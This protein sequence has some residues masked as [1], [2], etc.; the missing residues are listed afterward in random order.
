MLPKAATKCRTTRATATC[1]A[2]P[3]LRAKRRTADPSGCGS[4]AAPPSH[5]PCPWSQPW[6]APGSASAPG[7]TRRQAAVS[8][9]SSGCSS[10]VGA[11]LWRGARPAQPG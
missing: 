4:R 11:V 7:V 2:R 1:V 6:V 10:R 9:G 3:S 5:G 8:A